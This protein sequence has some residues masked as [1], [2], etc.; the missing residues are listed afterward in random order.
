MTQ[1]SY[2]DANGTNW[3]VWDV[4]PAHV[5]LPGG[6]AHLPEEVADGWLAF[7]SATEKRR[8]YPLP[9]D[10]ELLRDWQL[11]RLRAAAVVVPKPATGA[12]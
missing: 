10:W 6:N 4:I 12:D 5:K 1:R 2:T 7:E 3:R 8:F 11:D 9:P